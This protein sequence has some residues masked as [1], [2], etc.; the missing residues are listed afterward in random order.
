MPDGIQRGGYTLCKPGTGISHR[1][2]LWVRESVSSDCL[3]SPGP[4]LAV[5]RQLAMGLAVVRWGYRA[6]WTYDNGDK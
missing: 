5:W 2:A 6:S 1:P 4:T 3:N